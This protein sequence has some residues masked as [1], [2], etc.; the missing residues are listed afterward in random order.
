MSQYEYAIPVMLTKHVYEDYQ[1][2]TKFNP[3]CAAKTIIS[4]STFVKVFNRW[5]KDRCISERE[6]KNVSGKCDGIMLRLSHPLTFLCMTECEEIRA[7]RRE[8]KLSH[9]K[10]ARYETLQRQHSK[11]IAT[12]RG[13]CMR[14]EE[15]ARRP[16]PSVVC[17]H[18]SDLVFIP[19]V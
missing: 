5:K 1:M 17:I 13:F 10:W 14:D 8:A 7:A 3:R 11:D 2:E 18:V 12:W 16:C 15:L 6:K 19:F 4:H 9:D